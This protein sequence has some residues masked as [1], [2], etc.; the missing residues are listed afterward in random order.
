[1]AILASEKV[2]TLDYWKS[3]HTLAVGDHV[4][5]REGRLVRI[6]LI[7]QYR[8]NDCYRVILNDHLSVAGDKQ[9]GFPIENPKYRKRTYEYKG[10]HKF[11]RPLKPTK[12][13]T[14]LTSQLKNKYGDSVYS[15]PSA[16]PLELPH[17]ALSIPPFIFGYWFF[18]RRSTKS[19]AAPRG[20]FA[21]VE[22]QFKEHGYKITMGSKIN[23]G[24]REFSVFPT[25]E[26][27]IFPDSPQQIP[28]NYILG[29][30][31]QRLELLRGIL[32][33]KPR[34][35]SVSHDRF[36]FTCKIVRIFNQ[37]QLLAESLGHRTTSLYDK[38]N[39]T[40]VL[41]FK[42]RLKLVDEQVSP[43]IKVH[44]MRRYIKEIE[45]LGAQLCVHIETEGADNSFLVGAGF[46]SCL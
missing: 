40:Y 30:A 19:M 10:K 38:T 45:P 3:A 14:L 2:L 42:S 9:L 4:F 11:R 36:R 1:M 44:H 23:T 12:L 39:D 32:H 46:I 34:Q 13:E 29:S 43:P 22:R 25:I 20:R 24:E 8:A 18:N 16:K 15:I 6:K 31:E 35:Y 17:Q 21:E 41:F 28:N 27:Q 33:A 5:D 37:V 26:S 7:Q